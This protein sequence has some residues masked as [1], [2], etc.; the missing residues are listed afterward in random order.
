MNKIN[1]QKLLFGRLYSDK[2]EEDPNKNLLCKTHK[3]E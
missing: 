2:F 3:E 1:K